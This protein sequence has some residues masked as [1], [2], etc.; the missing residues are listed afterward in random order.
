MG[1]KCCETKRMAN[2]DGTPSDPGWDL[3]GPRMGPGEGLDRT[4]RD[5]NRLLGLSSDFRYRRSIFSTE[6]SFGGSLWGRPRKLLFSHFELLSA[7]EKRGLWEGVVQEP[8]R[9]ALFCV[10]CVLR[11]FC[12]ANLTEISFRNCPSNAGIFW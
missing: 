10:F 7:A 2:L 9:R 1:P 12:P 3:D 6:G 5:S 4:P 8:L 11:R